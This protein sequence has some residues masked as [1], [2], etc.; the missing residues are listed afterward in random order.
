MNRQEII[1][2]IAEDNWE[3]VDKEERFLN[4]L[5]K[6]NHK[7]Y[8]TIHSLEHLKQ[9]SIYKLKNQDIGFAITPDHEIVSVH[10]NSGVHK[11]GRYLVLKAVELGGNKVFHFDGWL[12]GFYS[13]L[14]FVEDVDQRLVWDEQYAPKDWK[15]EPVNITNPGFS[16]YA[17]EILAGKYAHKTIVEISKRYSQG[18]P[19]VITRFFK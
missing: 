10:N 8:L 12:T 6:S 3:T 5:I 13:N 18:R 7:E 15:Y 4:S 19:D 16:V 1:S 14:G 17:E 2:Q 11:L 9:F